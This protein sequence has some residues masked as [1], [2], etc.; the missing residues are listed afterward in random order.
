MLLAAHAVDMSTL[1]LLGAADDNTKRGQSIP[2]FHDERG[3]T[4]FGEN[5][6]GATGVR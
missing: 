5:G 2:R 4:F 3:Y 1:T 6:I